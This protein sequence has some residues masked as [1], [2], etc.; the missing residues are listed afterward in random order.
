MVNFRF[1]SPSSMKEL[2]TICQEI[3]PIHFLAGGTEL[4]PRIKHRA[5][6]ADPL[7]SL[8]RVPS[9]NTVEL[10][11]DQLIIGSMT[12]LDDLSRSSLVKAVAPELARV[13]GN[14]SHQEA[15]NRGTV[16]GN[17]CQQT[18]CWHFNRPQG[19]GAAPRELCFKAG[20]ENCHVTGRPGK[21]YAVF[22]GHLAPLLIALQAKA[23]L[24]SPVG[25]RAVPLEEIYSGNAKTPLALSEGELISAILVP[26]RGGLRARFIA[27][28]HRR[29]VDFP[30]LGV[31]VAGVFD[32]NDPSAP[33]TVFKSNPTFRI[34]LNGVGPAP[35]R[36]KSVEEA[37]AA[38]VS[39][40]SLGETLSRRFAEPVTF[41]NNTAWGGPA[42]R[43]SLPSVI[44]RCLQELQAV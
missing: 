31:A 42:L 5:T 33:K 35:L 41:V 12:T 16:G 44:T 9:L 18:R 36:A 23:I 24:V 29:A 27:Y 6:V 39:L 2:L 15:R 32:S 7:V 1:L 21:C 43:K 38:G 10:Q 26:Q 30:L 11:S 22:R 20:G 28:T 34:V 14:V 3:R 17:L 8:K 4:L 25:E 37:L 19:Y 40:P 13:A